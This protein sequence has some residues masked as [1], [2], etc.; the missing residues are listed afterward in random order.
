MLPML[1]LVIRIKELTR[2]MVVGKL[3]QHT[4][5]QIRFEANNGGDEYADFVDEELKKV[6]S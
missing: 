5:H 6:R 1:F 3:L 4:P 2:P